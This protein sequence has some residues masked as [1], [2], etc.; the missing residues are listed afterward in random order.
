MTDLQSHRDECEAKGM[1]PYPKKQKPCAK[2]TDATLSAFKRSYVTMRGGQCH[3]YKA[4]GTF[5]KGKQEVIQNTGFFQV[6]LQKRK[7][8]HT[9][10]NATTGHS[11]D[12]IGMVSK[13]GMLILWYSENKLPRDTQKDEQKE[14]ERLVNEFAETVKSGRVLYSIVTD[15]MD[16]VNQYQALYNS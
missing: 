13:S 2:E 6:T 7:A 1:F 15:R 14:F 3:T 12:T 5:R 9:K 4:G 11:D 10:S 8:G 16:F